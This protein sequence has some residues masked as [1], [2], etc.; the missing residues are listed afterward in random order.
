[1]S[2]CLVCGE[3]TE[4]NILVCS[5]CDKK[6]SRRPWEA[7]NKDKTTQYNSENQE[8]I[9]SMKNDIT[10]HGIL[11]PSKNPFVENKYAWIEQG[12]GLTEHRKRQL[13]LLL[14]K[15][16][17]EIMDFEDENNTRYVAF[18]AVR[19]GFAEVIEGVLK[20]TGKL[21]DYKSYDKWG[22]LK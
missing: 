15:T 18:V 9:E 5:K 14:D 1:M 4:N 6:V 10:K 20:R 12:Y 22:V 17:Q 3:Y 13:L 8:N 19:W 2:K 21:D 16:A 7:N 11:V